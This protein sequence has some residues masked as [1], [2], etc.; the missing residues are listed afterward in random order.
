MFPKLM[1]KD[2]EDGTPELAKSAHFSAENAR[3]SIRI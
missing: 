1:R 2:W 3:R